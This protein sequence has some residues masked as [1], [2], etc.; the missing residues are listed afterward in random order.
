MA[1]GTPQAQRREDYHTK[2]DTTFKC[3][4]LEFKISHWTS[5]QMNA[6]LTAIPNNFVVEHS[7]ADGKHAQ[8]RNSWGITTNHLQQTAEQS[9]TTCTWYRAY[10]Q[11]HHPPALS[12]SSR[13]NRLAHLCDHRKEIPLSCSTTVR[14]WCDEKKVGH[15]ILMWFSTLGEHT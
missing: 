10:S 13:Q 3:F 7:G 4:R 14:T 1:K 9:A 8:A 12:P 5:W 6:H 2:V 11:V 15:Q